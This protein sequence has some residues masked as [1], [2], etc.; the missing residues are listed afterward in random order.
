M[1]PLSRRRLRSTL[2]SA[3]AL[4]TAGVALA[5]AP[6]GTAAT[7]A[8]TVQ[9]S[10]RTGGFAP[11]LGANNLGAEADRRTVSSDGRYVVFAASGPVV[12]GQRSLEWQVVRRDRHLGTTTLVSRST[13]GVMGDGHSG[14]PSISADGN[15]IAFHS[16][17]ANLVPD[18]T[19]GQS[20]VFVHD[21][22]TGTTTRVNVTSAGEQVTHDGPG[23][24]PTGRPSI[25]ADGRHVGFVSSA[26]GLAPGDDNHTQAYLHDL[27]TRT[28]E[29]VSRSAV[30]TVVDA[31]P[32]SAVSVS[33][34][35]NRVAFLSL[36]ADVVPGDVN[37][38]LDVFVRDRAADT[39]HRVPAGEDGAGQHSLSADGNRVAFVSTSILADGADGS[40]QA[41]V[42]DL[43]EG[44]V[45]HASRSSDGAWGNAASSHPVLS[46]DGRYVAFESRADNLVAGDTNGVFDVFRHDL[47]TGETVRVSV[48]DSGAQADDESRA[49]SIS[50]DG[51]HVAFESYGSSLTPA[52]TAGYAQEYVR[53]LQG[54]FR[55]LFAA[56]PRLP[57]RV[58]AS[59]SGRVATRDI[60]TGPALEITWQP[61]GGT[62]GKPVVRRAAVAD[63]A[64]VLKA[65]GPG[66]AGQYEVTVTYD[67]NLV[68]RSTVT[69]VR[70]AVTNL[71]GQAKRNKPVTIRTAGIDRGEKVD[72][73]FVPRGATKGKAVDRTARVSAKGVV[74]VKAASREGTYRIVVRHGG[75]VLKQG[76]IRIR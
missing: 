61:T 16:Y 1:A 71:P 10:V 12:P 34:D 39:T 20:D 13:E 2:A 15:L 59:S 74:K 11:G 9:V 58:N 46:A 4:A 31:Y 49:P 51:Q 30:G 55:A 43:D 6:A 14:S 68:I 38:D 24:N 44:R 66:R 65:L 26:E 32:G 40:E 18:D 69:V 5:L 28:T 64:F 53:D 50:G 21:V 23:V 36:S 19:N 37:S 17:A 25:S 8:T 45:R 41:Y 52:G 75:K 27:A 3:T 67:G 57:A 22:R 47:A 76:Q 7:Q 63:D 62:K 42:Y 54:R 48:S 35:G 72:V 60:R 56:I 29:V 73:R 33:E 70:P